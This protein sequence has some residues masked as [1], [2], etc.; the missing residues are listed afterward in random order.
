M[1]LGIDRG[2]EFEF[3]FE[4][5]Y[6]YVKIRL[7]GRWHINQNQTIGLLWCIYTLSWREENIIACKL[8]YSFCKYKSLIG[9]GHVKPHFLVC[10]VRC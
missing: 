2:D 3:E 4:Y 7:W 1:R 6:E 9:F 8:V 5:G 10:L